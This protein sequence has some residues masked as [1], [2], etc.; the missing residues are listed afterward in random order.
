[1]P[2]L[3]P[4]R[5]SDVGDFERDYAREM[6]ERFD[7]ELHNETKSVDTDQPR[8]ARREHGAGWWYRIGLIA[9]I[10]AAGAMVAVAVSTKPPA[11]LGTSSLDLDLTRTSPQERDATQAPTAPDPSET[12]AA[13]PSPTPSDKRSAPGAPLLPELEPDED[14]PADEPEL[15]GMPDPVKPRTAP[16]PETTPKAGAE[17]RSPTPTPEP[18]PTPTPTPTEGGGDRRGGLVPE[19]LCSLLCPPG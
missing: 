17:T 5:G 3:Y 9:A 16:T 1:M 11:P 10:L 6:L 19:L 8:H 2:H 4:V 12:P 14:V 13:T 15:T 18:E 7:S